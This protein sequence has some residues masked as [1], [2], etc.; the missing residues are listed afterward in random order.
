[1]AKQGNKPP[2]QNVNSSIIGAKGKKTA[3]SGKRQ[4]PQTVAK[5]GKKSYK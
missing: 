2:V 5:G 4:P 3:G 1:M